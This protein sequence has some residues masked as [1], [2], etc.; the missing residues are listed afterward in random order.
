VIIAH[1]IALSPIGFT[2][3][4]ASGRPTTPGDRRGPLEQILTDR[5]ATHGPFQENSRISQA[6]KETMRA[7]SGWGR[8][9]PAMRESLEMDCHKVGRILA[10]DPDFADH[11]LDRAGYAT[12]IAKACSK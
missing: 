8:L 2:H 7:C 5:G 11:W 10:G 6:L 12:L 9:T 4:V 1:R 3:Q